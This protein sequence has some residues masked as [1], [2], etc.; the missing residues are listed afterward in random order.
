MAVSN[1]APP[2]ISR[3]NKPGVRRAMASAA[4]SI[5][6]VRMRVANKL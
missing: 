6:S 2:H 3:L 4:L 5:S 1:V